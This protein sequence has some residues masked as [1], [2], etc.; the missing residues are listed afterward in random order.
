MDDVLYFQKKLYRALKVPVSRLEPETGFDIG[1]DSE[2]S[3][4][5]IKFQKFIARIRLKFARIFEAAL[6]KQLILKG[7]ITADDWPMLRREMR[8][9]FIMPIK[10][11]N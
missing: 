8:Y 5:E 6:E 4:D 2:I 7:V 10:N 1:R 9:D 3:R 11:I